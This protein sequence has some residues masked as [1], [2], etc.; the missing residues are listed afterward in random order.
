[1]TVLGTATLDAEGTATFTAGP[2]ALGVGV[3][4]ITATY[5]GDGTFAPSTSALTD[6][7]TP[8][9]AAAASYWSLPNFCRSSN[10]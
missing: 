3:H 8:V 9:A 1:M 7:V 6:T 10:S 2:F 4:S 5:A